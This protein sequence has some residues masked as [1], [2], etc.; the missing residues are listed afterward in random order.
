MK[1]NYEKLMDQYCRQNKEQISVLQQK[2][3]QIS[4][5]LQTMDPDDNLL[6]LIQSSS[7]IELT[8]N[9]E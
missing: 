2:M 9:L 4:N 7:H 3:D 8:K 1:Q 5:K 6:E